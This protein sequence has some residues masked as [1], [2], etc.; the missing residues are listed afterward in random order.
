MAFGKPR[1]PRCAG[2]DPWIEQ[3]EIVW[4]IDDRVNDAVER[5]HHA[6][7]LDDRRA[8]EVPV[9][10][11]EQLPSFA[12]S[13]G[14][15]RGPQPIRDPGVLAGMGVGESFNPTLQGLSAPIFKQAV[16]SFPDD[17]SQRV[18]VAI[19][20]IKTRGLFR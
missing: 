5:R 6:M 14:V 8:A 9:S 20:D 13:M 19:A 1:S 15:A 17:V 3:F 18:P 16:C 11:R 4:I 10:L 2:L 7:D 12:G